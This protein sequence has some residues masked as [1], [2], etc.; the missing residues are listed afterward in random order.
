ME[1]YA[2]AAVLLLYALDCRTYLIC[3]HLPERWSSKPR[4]VSERM[5]CNPP[6]F[7]SG[8]SP[9]CFHSDSH[10]QS[11]KIAQKSPELIQKISFL[12]TYNPP[13]WLLL[14]LLP[15]LHLSCS[16]ASAAASPKQIRQTSGEASVLSRKVW[17]NT[18][19][20]KGGEKTKNMMLHN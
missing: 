9:P 20:H 17:T 7:T 13:H 2:K 4:C 11:L 1:L 16:S 14:C 18:W 12:S 3:V 15:S 8:P 5:R 19:G 10:N 6:P